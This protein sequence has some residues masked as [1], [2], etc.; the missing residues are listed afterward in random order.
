MHSYYNLHNM[1]VCAWWLYNMSYIIL[2]AVT[3]ADI[4]LSKVPQSRNVSAGAWVEFTCATEESGVTSFGMTTTPPFAGQIPTSA[5]LPDGGRQQTLSFTAPSEHS[6]ITI[7]CVA[8][9]S[10]DFIETTA[11]LM[12][13]GK[14]INES[15]MYSLNHFM[16]T[17]R[18][19]V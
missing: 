15:S 16:Y 18:S 6:I 8:I 17:C 9:R 10:P 14:I 7:T 19:L 5:A 1:L 12:I 13:Q 3:H 11:I 4:I 2:I